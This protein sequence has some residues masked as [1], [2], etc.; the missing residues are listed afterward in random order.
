MFHGQFPEFPSSPS[1]SEFLSSLPRWRCSSPRSRG[2]GRQLD[3]APKR[4]AGLRHQ[5]PDAG[6]RHL[7]RHRPAV[8]LSDESFR[9]N[10]RK[11]RRTPEMLPSSSLGLRF[12]ESSASI[13]SSKPLMSMKFSVSR[14]FMQ[15]TLG[16]GWARIA[17]TCARTCGSAY[18][19]R[20]PSSFASRGPV[21]R[22]SRT[23]G[24]YQRLRHRIRS[25]FSRAAVHRFCQFDQFML[26]KHSRWSRLTL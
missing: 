10:E 9:M 23:G 16:S 18:R 1:R 4:P 21:C 5:A 22:P 15:G 20:W 6:A 3:R 25:A 26:E 19:C 2:R 11:V 13:S 17:A 7:V 24:P 8:I 14:S 12:A